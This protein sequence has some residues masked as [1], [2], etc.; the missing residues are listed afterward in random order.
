VNISFKNNKLEQ[1]LSADQGLAKTFGPLAKKV[2]QRMTQL[3]SADNL[4]IIAENKVLR[5]HPYKGSRKGE[6]SIDI[7]ENWRII[8]LIDHEPIPTLA[9]GG[10][11]LKEITIIKIESVEDPH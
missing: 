4:Q 3:K 7:Q 6:W 1:Q 2:R 10:V 9:D 11:N 8:F 5:L